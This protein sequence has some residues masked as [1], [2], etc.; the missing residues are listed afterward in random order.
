MVRKRIKKWIDGDS[1]V[2]L[3]NTRFR[4]AD[5]R[6]PEKN[7]RG[8]TTATR[9]AAGITGRSGGVINVKQIAT[10]KYGRA[11]VEMSN[12][13]GSVNERLRKKGYTNKGR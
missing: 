8:G 10:D 5:V 4:L 1:G 9:V 7:K 13:D 3:D 2:F 11:I 12:G 6:A